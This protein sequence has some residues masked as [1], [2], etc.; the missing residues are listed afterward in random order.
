[1]SGATVLSIIHPLEHA[2]VTSSREG[3][4]NG[5]IKTITSPGMFREF[6]LSLP[7]TII[8]RALYF[9]L[10]DSMKVKYACGDE[11]LGF[12]SAFALALV[13]TT[14][15]DILALSYYAV[16]VRAKTGFNMFSIFK[17]MHE[18]EQVRVKNDGVTGKYFKVSLLIAI[19]KRSESKHSLMRHAEIWTEMSTVHECVKLSIS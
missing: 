8:H 16:L 5:L 4:A 14:F 1:S 3:L 18:I 12:F 17:K 13:T 7:G 6:Y 9:G 11:K 2:I 19:L 10:Y 15:S